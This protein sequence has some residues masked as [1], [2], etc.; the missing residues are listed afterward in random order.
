MSI[1]KYTD[2]S[3]L[4][5]GFDFSKEVFDLSINQN[6]W[7]SIAKVIIKVIDKILLEPFKELIIHVK[8]IKNEL[9]IQV[10]TSRAVI[11]TEAILRVSSIYEEGKKQVEIKYKELSVSAKQKMI[12]NLDRALEKQIEDIIQYL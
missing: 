12:R 11:R 3:G 1:L 8:E 9:N 6:I 10:H 2:S 5:I 4:I 7:I